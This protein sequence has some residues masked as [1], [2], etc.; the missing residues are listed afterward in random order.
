MYI[1]M[2]KDLS[3][4]KSMVFLSGPRQVGK[5]TLAKIIA[6]S[7][8]NSLYFNWDLEQ[9]R[10][11][12]LNDPLFF[13]KV[14]RRDQSR[15]LII[16]DEIHKHRG[17]KNFLKGAYDEFHD[18]YAFLVTGSGRLDLY[19]RG[20]DSLAGRYY[21]FHLWPFTVAELG[22]VNAAPEGFF[23]DPLAITMSRSA[24]LRQ[25]WARIGEMSGFPEPFLAN[26]PRTYRMWSGTYSRQLI[27]E[28]V[29]DLT[30]IRQV[31]DLEN[32]YMLLPS[33]VGSPLSVPSLASDLKVS[34]NA[35]RNWLAVFER[36]FLIFTISPWTQNVA[37][38]IQKERKAYLLD[39]PR[40]ADPASRFEN[41]VAIELL[42]GVTAW[43]E[44]G[45]GNFALHF[46]R[47]R[48]KQEVDFLIIRDDKPFLLVEAK[49]K[50][51]APLAALRAFQ[52]Q[53]GVPAVQLVSEGETFQLVRNNGNPLLVAPA[54]QWL[55]QLP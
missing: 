2:W 54:Y 39:V 36:F 41:M 49:L 17:W 13:E 27:R 30:E 16:F 22:D 46:V 35:V 37:H 42:R 9:H 5:T 10:A 7:F 3:S 11:L 6:T 25:I 52:A 44:M 23:D 4:E 1:R 15:P 33:K 45:H 14:K 38:A 20:G 40:I 48:F 34:Y 8:A 18:E 21:L 47:N 31:G 29:R 12:L 53:L 24:E 55:A 28:D 19:Q 26:R 51:E 32:L 50:D 43:N